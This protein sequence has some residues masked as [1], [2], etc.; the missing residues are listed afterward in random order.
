MSQ[1]RDVI[2]VGAG[3]IGLAA[4]WR[5][6]QRGA[7]VA[8]IDRGEP[9]AGATRV[10]AGMLAPVTEAESEAEPL[11]EARLTAAATWPRFA[12]ERVSIPWFA[13]GGIDG[14]NV[15]EVVAAGAARIAVVRA[16]GDAADPEAAARKLRGSLP[17]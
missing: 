17:D 9:G 8:V 6:A 1:K 15:D 16:I 5:I 14:S 3:V 12:A 7:S 13:I 10:S 4:A 11:I 2:V